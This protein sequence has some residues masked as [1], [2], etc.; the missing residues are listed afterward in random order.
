MLCLRKRVDFFG[1]PT[2]AEWGGCRTVQY[3]LRL[4]GVILHVWCQEGSNFHVRLVNRGHANWNDLSCKVFICGVQADFDSIV[5]T[6]GQQAIWNR[7][8]F[9]YHNYALQY[10][11]LQT[12]FVLV[13]HKKR[14]NLVFGR[15]I[16]SRAVTS[17]HFIN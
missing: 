12:I 13:C 14:T 2:K 9:S 15:C 3:V 6:S 17:N 5:R 8:L 7:L 10:N 11:Y 1:A 4:E 16:W